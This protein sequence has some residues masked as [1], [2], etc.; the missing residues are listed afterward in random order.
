MNI[1]IEELYNYSVYAWYILY[2]VSFLGLY[3]NAPEYLTTIDFILRT[4]VSLFLVFRFNPFTKIHFT[5]F[6]RKII[7]SA[8]IFLILSS[9]I[10]SLY[11]SKIRQ[12]AS[13]KAQTYLKN[14]IDD[15]SDEKVGFYS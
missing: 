12:H 14:I 6:D 4:Y 15:N 7:F 1:I 2:A 5:E 11:T 13:E 10:T 8:G 9:T 3:S